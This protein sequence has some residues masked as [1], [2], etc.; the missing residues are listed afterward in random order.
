MSDLHVPYLSI[1]LYSLKPLVLWGEINLSDVTNSHRPGRFASR[2]SHTYRGEI[3]EKTALRVSRSASLREDI[4]NRFDKQTRVHKPSGKH[5]KPDSFDGDIIKLVKQYHTKALFKCDPGHEHKA[6]KKFKS[7]VIQ[8]DEIP[9][10]EWVLKN[11][12]KEFNRKHYY[13]QFE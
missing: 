5:R 11:G 2:L 13:K 10:K 12:L 3:A 8:L 1:I 9:F 7:R 4:A 6:F